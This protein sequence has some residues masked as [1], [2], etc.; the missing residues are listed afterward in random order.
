[1]SSNILTKILNFIKNKRKSLKDYM[2][3]CNIRQLIE[4]T[5]E[6]GKNKLV[7]I[8]DSDEYVQQKKN[9]K[10]ELWVTLA[11]LMAY[12][13]V[14]KMFF[15]GFID[16][17]RIR[18]LFMDYTLYSNENR[19]LYTLT[20]I[21]L[22]VIML[23]P[24]QLQYLEMSRKFSILKMYYLI[25]Y[26]IIK[27]PLTSENYRKY[28]FYFKIISLLLNNSFFITWVI[29]VSIGHIFAVAYSRNGFGIYS[30]FGQIFGN[31]TFFL[32]Y[33]CGCA[34]VF[35][36]LILW[37]SSFQYLKYK[38]EEI[39]TK[40]ELSLKQM[41]IILLMNAI[42]EHNYVERLTRDVNAL[43]RHIIFFGYYGLTLTSQLFLFIAQRKDT[44]LNYRISLY[45]TTIAYIFILIVM[46]IIC[47]QICSRAHQSYS[48]IFSIL[49][50]ENIRIS[51][52][53]RLKLMSFMEKLSG[54]QIG[55]YCYDLFAVN[56]IEFYEYISLYISNYFLIISLFP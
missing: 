47:E 56:R 48:T 44:L 55:F 29:I 19:L 49:V 16:D 25:K 32:C 35:L 10:R 1:M 51:F 34:M 6:F 15:L 2:T 5:E 54:P 27:Y 38:F 43:I 24:F 28:C 13:H 31:I 40:I 8:Y 53:Q 39:N 4:K 12:L 11:K 33:Y 23:L 21:S 18:L 17:I 42:H 36:G 50:K 9:H 45:L 14:Y 41:N 46:H 3:D 52:K 22:G 30:I 37:F 7:L 20:F 26:R